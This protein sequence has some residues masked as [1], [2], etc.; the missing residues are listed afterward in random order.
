LFGLRSKDKETLHKEIFYFLYA[1][2]GSFTY[3]EIYSM[4]VHLRNF[5]YRELSEARQKQE[6]NQQQATMSS[7]KRRI[8]QNSRFKR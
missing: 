3:S 4:P 1:T 5:Y 7:N 2:N 8:S 6:Q